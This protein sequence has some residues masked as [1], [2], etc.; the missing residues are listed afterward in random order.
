[1]APVFAGNRGALDRTVQPIPE[2][3]PR[4]RSGNA[5]PTVAHTVVLSGHS[6]RFSAAATFE[7]GDFVNVNIE[8]R[9]VR[10]SSIG[11]PREPKRASGHEVD[12]RHSVGM[13]E[14][15]NNI[16]PPLSA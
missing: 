8:L 16:K 4:P 12:S 14:S 15:G 5:R 9:P 10:K 13:V 1:M 3:H 7:P 11:I 6:C 2:T